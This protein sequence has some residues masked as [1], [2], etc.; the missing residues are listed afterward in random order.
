MAVDR[1]DMGGARDRISVGSGG[2]EFG[3]DL[4]RETVDNRSTLDSVVAAI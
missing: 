3:Y 1:W 4:H 2:N